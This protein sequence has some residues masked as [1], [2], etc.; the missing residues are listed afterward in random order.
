MSSDKIT[1]DKRAIL[2]DLI[3]S[4]KEVTVKYSGAKQLITAND[5]GVEKLLI[6]LENTILYGLKSSFLDNLLF[7][8]SN[9]SAFWNFAAQHLT[10]DEQKRFASYKNVS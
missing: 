5:A 8:N 10:K 3:N 1:D 9:G 2:N 4:V 6:S 7:T